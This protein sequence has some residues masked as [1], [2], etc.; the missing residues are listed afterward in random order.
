[1]KFP[2]EKKDISRL[3]KSGVKEPLPCGK[4]RN[5]NDLLES[6]I[7]IIDKPQGPTSHQVS[8]Y[9]RDILK[10]K[11]CGHSG[12]LD[13]NVTGVLPVALSRSTKVLQAL[14]LAGKEYV[15]LM[16][17]H[18]PV[19][20]GDIRQ[21]CSEFVG[22]ITQ[23]PPVKSA[24]KRQ[25]RKREVYYIK[26]LEI[27]GQDVLFRVGCQA[28]TYIRKLC[29]D[30]GE[31]LGVGAHMQQ[32]VRTRVAS[33]RYDERVTLQDLT[34]AYHYYTQNQ[35][36]TALRQIVQPIEKA[37][38]HIPKIW[39]NTGVISPLCHG[40]QLA[41]PGIVQLDSHIK[42][43]DICAILSVQG[44]LVALAESLTDAHEL[45]NRQKGI[46][47]KTI[48]VILNPNTKEEKSK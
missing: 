17:I 48:R 16:R 25:L 20:E 3:Y 34:D 35:D 21:I 2:Y 18:K 43:G 13:P 36:E 32:L 29:T 30:I 33:F 6:G 12:T 31:K 38:S 7:V 44:E 8:A 5:M 39:V 41:I 4:E 46:A 26:I 27:H 22:V 37:V 23:M 10:I 14:L 9:V 19:R 24:I 42:K 15:C 45:M 47:T 40:A 1:M 28:G 11:H